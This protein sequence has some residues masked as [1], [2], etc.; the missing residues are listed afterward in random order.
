MKGVVGLL[1][2]L[3]VALKLIGVIDWSWIWVTAPFWGGLALMLVVMLIT[4][5]TFFTAKIVEN[6]RKR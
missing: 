1:G 5:A 4:L 2:V 6:Q 3:F